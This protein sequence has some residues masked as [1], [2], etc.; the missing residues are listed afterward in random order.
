MKP[1]WIAW[2]LFLSGVGLTSLS[3]LIAHSL[4]AWRFWRQDHDDA[5]DRAARSSVMFA[6]ISVAAVYWA[7]GAW[8]AVAR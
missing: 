1:A 3:L 7:E 5:F 4:D 8:R 2:A 6:I